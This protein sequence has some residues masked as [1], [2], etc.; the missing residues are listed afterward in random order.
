METSLRC[1]MRFESTMSKVLD[2]RWNEVDGS[3][4][5][6]EVF[7]IMKEMTGVRTHVPADD[8]YNNRVGQHEVEVQDG[9]RESRLT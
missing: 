4:Y 9:V 5:E 6:G 7:E 1:D 2:F 3:V 8:L